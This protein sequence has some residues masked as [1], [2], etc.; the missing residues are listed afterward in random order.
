MHLASLLYGLVLARNQ[1]ERIESHGRC[2][3]RGHAA[4]IV[5]GAHRVDVDTNDVQPRA[6]LK[7]CKSLTRGRASPRRRA[8]TR[9]NR[10]IEEVHVVRKIDRPVADDAADVC[11]DVLD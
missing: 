2:E 1:V 5:W 10:G 3:Q 8:Y 11:E 4:D 7:N 9:S 6:R